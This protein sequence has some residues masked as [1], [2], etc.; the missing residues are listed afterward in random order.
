M[1]GRILQQPVVNNNLGVLLVNL[2]T[3]D[4]P[5]VPAVKRYLAEFLSDPR[6]IEFSKPIWQLILH[7][8]ILPIRSRQSAKRYQKIWQDHD[9]PMRAIAQRQ[10]KALQRLLT[11]RVGEYIHVALGMTYG[12]PSIK[13]ALNELNQQQIEKLIVLPLFPQY[14][15]TTTAAVFDKL[16]DIFK[17]W[18]N[19]P[20][21][22]FIKNY[23]NHPDFIAAQAQQL[24]NHWEHNQ[25][26]EKLIFSF[27]GIPERYQRQGDPYPDQCHQCA[28]LIA[29][30]LQLDSTQ[31]QTTFQSRFARGK[32][33]KPYTDSTLK[34]WAKQG[35]KAVDIVSP[36]FSADCL[37]TLEELNIVNRQLFLNAGGEKYHY[38]PALNDQAAHIE[39]FAVLVMERISMTNL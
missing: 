25:R 28:T 18:R 36:A 14:S 27:H 29:N 34:Q 33:I 23:Y 7:G 15:A 30:K 10:T 17:K 6:I 39:L 12:N 22:H 37:E 9:S 2:G 5:T 38:I 8:I 20:E 21:L 26:G 3:P 1:F 16:G 31:W 11:D 32:W 24:Q 35:I 13:A 4:A 19:I